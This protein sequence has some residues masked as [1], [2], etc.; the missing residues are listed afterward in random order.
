MPCFRGVVENVVNEVQEQSTLQ[1]VNSTEGVSSQTR[2]VISEQ[3]TGLSLVE[4]IG[5]YEVS[6]GIFG[7]QKVRRVK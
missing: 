3:E 2:S 5:T 7:R 1:D 4:N 6:K